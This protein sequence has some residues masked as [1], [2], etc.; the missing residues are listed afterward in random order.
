[1]KKII[2][3]C[4]LGSLLA[5]VLVANEINVIDQGKNDGNGG[6]AIYIDVEYVDDYYNPIANPAFQF[7]PY[8]LNR[9]DNF[10]VTGFM[11][12]G[13]G[14]YRLFIQHKCF[15]QKVYNETLS[16]TILD[17]GLTKDIPFTACEGDRFSSIF[18]T[19]FPY[20]NNENKTDIISPENISPSGKYTVTVSGNTEKGYD[21]VTISHLHRD[22]GTET[23]IAKLSGVF[24]EIYL[25]ETS[26]DYAP[27]IGVN[28][29]SDG[30]VVPVGGGV[31]VE[32]APIER[33]QV[34]IEQKKLSKKN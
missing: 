29:T 24:N 2:K 1:M 5:N 27:V 6:N 34:N 12:L 13:V 28:F 23:E 4:L 15:E 9:E 21:F 17:E 26:S 30:S 31:R 19:D 22:D 8:D 3:I 20:A 14:K 7:I 10:K 16:F 32:I 25:V 33:G 11:R 18:A